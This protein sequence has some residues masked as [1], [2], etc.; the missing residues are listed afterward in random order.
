[1]LKENIKAKWF[2]CARWLCRLFCI[3]FFRVRS[4]GR[5]NIPETG[6]FV[7]ISNHQSFLDPMLCGIPL[8]RRVSFLARETLFNHWL[9]GRMITSVGT[10][11]VK[12][13]EG[14]ISA[15]RKAVDILKQDRG[16]CL[17]PEGTRS[18]DGKI[19]PFKSGFG[20]LCRRGNAAVVPVVIDGAFECWP[21]HKK[22]FS[23][24]SIVVDYGRAIPAEQAKKMSNEKL[25]EVLTKTLRRMQN[26]SR[27][28]QGKKP[29]DY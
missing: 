16:I 21:R 9:F 7:L 22:L 13:G 24:G 11:P 29:Y 14:D 23:R 6:P 25:A 26:K 2:W 28:K 17:F 5:D 19:T 10:I 18:H 1:M 12:L 15:I 3:L 20:L 8:K 4:Y 27:I